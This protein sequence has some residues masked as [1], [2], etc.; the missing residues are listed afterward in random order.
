MPR[1]R[2]LATAI[3]AFARSMLAALWHPAFAGQQCRLQGMGNPS[4]T[5]CRSQPSGCN[6]LRSA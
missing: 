6:R 1:R 2:T 5:S 3:V 4:R